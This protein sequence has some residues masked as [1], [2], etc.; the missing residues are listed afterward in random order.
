[1]SRQLVVNFEL[2]LQLKLFFLVS[3]VYCISDGIFDDKE[4]AA[5][6]FVLDSDAK[7]SNSL[8]SLI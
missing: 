3:L 5:I 8:P 2:Q 7:Y 4:H 6:F 1:M